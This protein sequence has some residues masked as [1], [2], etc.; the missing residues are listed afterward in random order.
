MFIPVRTGSSAEDYFYLLFNDDND[1]MILN[2][3]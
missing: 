2:R 3:Q 1:K